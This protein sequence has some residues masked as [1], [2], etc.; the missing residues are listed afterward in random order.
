MLEHA[1]HE[2]FSADRFRAQGH[3]LIDLLADYLKSAVEQPDKKVSAFESP[4]EKLARW[5]SALQS[6]QM[7][8]M[9]VFD[10]YLSETISLHNPRYVGHQVAVTHPLA[11]LADLLIG[12]KNAGGGLYEM[13]S[14]P[15]VAERSVISWMSESLG[16]GSGAGGFFTSGGTLGNLTALL[17]ARR[18]SDAGDRPLSIILSDQA[19]YSIAKSA[20]IMGLPKN[21]LIKIP[22]H[23]DRKM[24]GEDVRLA[25]GKAANEGK[26]VIAV[27]ANACS[28]ALGLYD[29]LREIGE[30]CARERVWF[31]VDGAHGAAACLSDRYRELVDGI[32]LCDSVIWDAHKMLMTPSLGAA[33]IFRKQEHA[34]QIFDH[35][36]SYVLK[37][38]A[39]DH[40]YDPAHN[41]IELTRR[42]FAFKV[43]ILLAAHGA[44]LFSSYVET[45]F[46]LA[47]KFHEMLAQ[48]R[49]FDAPFQPESNIV[50]FRY[51]PEGLTPE[52]L[53][54]LQ[55]R[56]REAI[57]RS[58]EYYLVKTD[59]PEGR[60]LRVSLMNPFTTPEH[61]FGLMRTIK[62]TALQQ[63]L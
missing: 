27:V 26:Q 3:A 31:H 48:D 6:G 35:Q 56:I 37:G 18:H 4:E 14:V 24:K 23:G 50:C 59:L 41:T 16:L 57:I 1:L 61:L 45:T 63:G 32:E 55:T 15:V 60:F 49:D 46:D 43:Y 20:D 62:K 7:N 10:R 40:W 21:A 25:I 11:A 19:H 30:I 2:S 44:Q 34:Y 17:C 58:G 42:D 13:G 39:A 47:R 8:P 53:D 38:K 12:I 22:T 9:D 54:T 36:A 29:P 51:R 52:A 28:T 33:V 5:H